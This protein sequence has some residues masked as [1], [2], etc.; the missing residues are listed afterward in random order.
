MNVASVEYRLAPEHPYPAAF[1]DALDATVFAL[2][3]EGEKILGGPLKVLMGESAG[4]C[5][6]SWV[7]LALRDR[8]QIDVR[9]RLSAI[10]ASYPVCDLSLTPSCIN[11]QREA[12]LSSD[13]MRRFVDVAFPG[14][15]AT[16]LKQPEVSPVYND[17]ERMPPSLW[18]C[19]TEDLL[20]DDSVLMSWR[21]A[22]AGNDST[23]CLIPGA[24]HGFTILPAGEITDDGHAEIEEFLKRYT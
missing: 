2:S 5:I 19:G 7:A 12:V 3:D 6:A 14:M 23:L 17:L 8:L 13:G 11:H 16:D 24:W 10:V 9:S 4:G 18:L 22:S 1:D 20:I 21:W 15:S